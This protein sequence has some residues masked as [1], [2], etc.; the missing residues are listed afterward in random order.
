MNKF[1]K[2][3]PGIIMP[4]ELKTLKGKIVYILIILFLAIVCV[5]SLLPTLWTL[6]TGFKTSQ[7]MYSSSKLF[8]ENMSWNWIKSNFITAWSAMNATKSSLNT[9]LISVSSTI[10]TIVVDGLGG[11]VLSRLKPKGIKFAFVLIVW[12]MMMPSQIRIVPLYI[13]YINWPFVAK[14]SWQL[15]LLNTYWPMIL[16]SATSAF[17]VVLFK[18]SFDSISISLVEAAKLDGCGNMRIFFNIMLP[19]SVPVII[20]VA[21]GTMRSPWSDF[22]NPY[23]ILKDKEKFTL[24]VVIY[25]LKGDSA[26]KMNTQMLC[27]VL[28][29]I[30]GL[31]IFMLFQKY[32]V[33]GIN[34]GGVKG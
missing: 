13:S 8:P 21:I 26:V 19:L 31:L 33:G 2:K 14:T 20:Y 1:S 18:N 12:T 3:T 34:V 27:L 16:G 23:L 5:M 6:L 22:F 28:S 15:N 17:S 29:S 7:E 11:Y 30:P 10:F 24:P 9:L 25:L 4:S 32:I